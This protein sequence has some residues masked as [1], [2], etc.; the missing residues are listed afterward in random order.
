MRIWL[1]GALA[2][3]AALGLVAAGLGATGVA[4]QATPLSYVALGDSYTA[5][6]L[7]PPLA[8]RAPLDC[9]QSASNYPHLTARALGLSL[10]DRSCTSADTAD[11]TTAQYLDQ[12]PQFK[13]LQPTTAVV[14]IGIGGNDNDLF[15]GALTSCG[16]LDAADFLNIGSPCQAV[17]GN[18]FAQ[19]ITADGPALKAA[20]VAIHTR[21]PLARVLV[22]GYPDILPQHGN[23]Y[24]LIPLTTADT[25]Y[26]NS[27]EMT[28][29]AELSTE[30]AAAGAT[31]VDT[32]SGSL[33]HDACKAE[34]VRWIEPIIPGTLAFP[35]HPN[36]NGEAHD[37][38]VVEAAIGAAGL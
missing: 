27:V 1:R 2:A 12:P 35:V 17:F 36:A 32:F 6:P 38:T 18:H 23:C 31:Y 30:A 15:V 19:E 21:S 4:A 7:V 29:N 8:A 33:G 20:F 16:A 37:A 10:V 34:G 28:L 22:I 26:L 24:P 25:A 14:T 13:A 3:T 9:L 5:A 11:M